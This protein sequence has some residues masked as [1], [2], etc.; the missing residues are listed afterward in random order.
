M[1]TGK[2]DRNTFNEWIDL[3]EAQHAGAL[4]AYKTLYLGNGADAKVVG[5]NLRDLDYGVVQGHGETRIAAA[6][7]VPAIIVGFSEGLE[8]STY[9]NFAQARRAFADK[10]LRPLWR[11]FCSSTETLVPPPGGAMLWYDDRDIAFL[12]ADVKDNADIQL[13]KATAMKLLTDAGF[14]PDSVVTAIEA[15]DL[16][17][18]SHSGLYSVQ[19]QP[20]GTTSSD[21]VP[22]PPTANG[23]GNG[24]NALASA[25][26]RGILPNVDNAQ[27]LAKAL[28]AAR[29]GT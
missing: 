7:G 10:T 8:A 6:A 20:P 27:Q 18:L 17:Q 9:S 14:E 12:K 23:N 2:M 15:D 11:N 29:A 13:T 5:T 22:T 1:D 19:L 4:N 28:L 26:Q 25:D 3:F 24:P 21:N 16:S